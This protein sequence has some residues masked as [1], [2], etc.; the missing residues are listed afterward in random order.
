MTTF[1]PR[2]PASRMAQARHPLFRRLTSAFQPL[3]A[4]KARTSTSRSEPNCRLRVGSLILE[5]G[6]GGSILDTLLPVEAA[7]A[8]RSAD[9]LGGV[10]SCSLVA[11]FV[12]SRPKDDEIEL[13][14]DKEAI[15][16]ERGG[17]KPVMQSM[18]R[19]LGPLNVVGLELLVAVDSSVLRSSSSVSSGPLR[20]STKCT[21]L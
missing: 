19:T 14:R 9:S 8:G 16:G 20:R 15:S 7:V 17:A 11:V 5:S 3:S 1:Q 12:G 10:G 21:A 13:I 2:A 4:H 6:L 18:T